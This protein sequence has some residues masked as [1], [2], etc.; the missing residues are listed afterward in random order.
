MESKCAPHCS[1]VI[2][3]AIEGNIGAGKSTFIE[4]LSLEFKRNQLDHIILPE[5]IYEWTHF[6]SDE[7]NLLQEMYDNKENANYNFQFAALL[8]RIEQLQNEKARNLIMERTIYAQLNVFLPLLKSDKKISNLQYELLERFMAQLVKIYHPSVIVY[9]RTTPEVVKMRIQSR[10]R[11]E[12][13]N[14][15][16][17]YLRQVHQKYENWLISAPNTIII[18]ADLI[19]NVNPRTIFKQ[20]LLKT[21][22]Q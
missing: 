12:E 11:P 4:N 16:L 3:C 9:L 19:K 13:S 5:P 22:N 8:T 10:G 7:I 15:T 18:E 21:I 14:I 17:E 1:P 20:L 2:S 6:G